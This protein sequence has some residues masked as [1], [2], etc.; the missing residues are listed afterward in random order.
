M[1]IIIDAAVLGDHNE[2]AKRFFSAFSAKHT[3]LT[4]QEMQQ[5]NRIQQLLLQ[6]GGNISEIA[7]RLGLTRQAVY[8]RLEG[9]GIKR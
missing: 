6:T 8:H 2:C 5:R 9:Y 7:R 4:E 3:V 1:S